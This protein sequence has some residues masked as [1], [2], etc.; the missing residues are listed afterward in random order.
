MFVINSLRLLP[1][2]DLIGCSFKLN[3]FVLFL[4][5]G[6]FRDAEFACDLG[7]FRIAINKKRRLEITLTNSK[8]LRTECSFVVSINNIFYVS[9]ALCFVLIVGQLYVFKNLPARLVIRILQ[10]FSI[11]KQHYGSSYLFSCLAIHPFVKLLFIEHMQPSDKAFMISCCVPTC[12]YALCCRF[13]QYYQCRRQKIASPKKKHLLRG[14]VS[15]LL[16]KTTFL[17]LF[18][19]GS[20]FR[21]LE[22]FGEGNEGKKM[23]SLRGF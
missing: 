21:D 5:Y 18:F 12:S 7:A 1:T 13:Q 6:H 20:W 14:T 10:R 15:I 9:Y 19:A 3:F 23:S 8:V 4:F 16:I 17:S 2:G 22:C 11:T